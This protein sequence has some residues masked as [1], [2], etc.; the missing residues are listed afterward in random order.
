M[1]PLWWGKVHYWHHIY[2]KNHNCV[3]ELNVLKN[4]EHYAHSLTPNWMLLQILGS[5]Q[6]KWHEN[7]TYWT[8]TFG[9]IPVLWFLLY[10][11]RDHIS[12]LL[13]DAPFGMWNQSLI[14]SCEKSMM[15][16]VGH[17]FHFMPEV[18]FA[19]L[20]WFQL[21]LL[22]HVIQFLWDWTKTKDLI[23]RWFGGYALI[24]EWVEHAGFH[25]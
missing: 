18:Q 22:N 8:S 9:L 5:N 21:A 4:V 10:K 15:L 11:Q 16:Y 24:F 7:M 3:I 14:P 12:L 23:E 19:A 17:M 25:S 1:I 6:I 20:P 13:L 2:F